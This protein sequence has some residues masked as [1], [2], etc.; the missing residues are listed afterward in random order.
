MTISNKMYFAI[1]DDDI[2]FFTK[3]EELAANYSQ[4]W[5]ECPISLAVTPFQAGY[6]VWVSAK[7]SPT[8]PAE[9]FPLGD[10]REL[11]EFLRDG[12][13]FGRFS[14]M[15][16]GYHHNIPSGR[17][18]FQE[19]AALAAKA[20][21]G[22]AYLERL[23]GTKITC[24]TPPH[25]ALSRE[26]IDAVVA[27]GLNIVGIQSFRPG[28]RT[29][30]LRHLVPF[31]ARNWY[32]RV[33]GEEY[34]RPLWV[35]DHWEMPY[36]TLGR[37]SSPELLREGILRAIRRRGT[38]CLSTHYW[39]FGYPMASSPSQ[40]VGDVFLEL[41]GQVRSSPGVAFTT[42]DNLPTCAPV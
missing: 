21:E 41:W 14:I 20:R 3:P 12:C 4:V 36:A 18:E 33:L 38:F 9:V 10:N 1:R 11:V 26:G 35:L 27:A 2:N 32:L 15:L 22:K 6:P 42:V 17:P 24:F 7:S 19:G 23:L 28:R 29:L 34:P 16:H 39:E 25:N 5:D 8:N 30:R 40:T 31:L 13:A 37:V